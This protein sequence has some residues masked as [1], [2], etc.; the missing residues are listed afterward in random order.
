MGCRESKLSNDDSIGG[1]NDAKITP[2]LTFHASQAKEIGRNQQQKSK[3]SRKKS[4][5]SPNRRTSGECRSK[6]RRRESRSCNDPRI[7]AKYD[8]KGVIGKGSYSRVVRVENRVT[9][10]PYAIKMIESPEGREVFEA[11]LSVLRRINHTNVIRLVEVF[12]SNRK[13]Y[14]V[15]ELATGG[16]LLDKLETKGSF[17]ESE[18][19]RVLKMVLNGVGYLH[20]LGIT[21][22]DLRPDNLLYYHPGSDSRILITDFGFASTR[23]ASGNPYMHTVCGVPHYIAPEVVARRPYTCSV[24]MWAVGVITYILLSG[25]FPFDAEQD[26]QIFKLI[27][28]GSFSMSNQVWENVSEDGKNFVR[29]LLQREPTSRLTAFQALEHLWICETSQRQTPG[30]IVNRR[31]GSLKSSR[32]LT[33]VRSGRSV[34]S[35]RSGHRRVRAQQLDVL[36]ADPEVAGMIR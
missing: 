15:M 17:C 27:L 21:H 8:V 31:P 2:V 25:T 9:K 34:H 12:E 36:K 29:S 32:S 1:D 33:S 11:E 35:L 18:A 5:R 16:S 7:T 30:R 10:Q 14:M 13:V 4:R 26:S 19:G 23:K 3:R 28:K 20:K 6:K 22:R 24:D